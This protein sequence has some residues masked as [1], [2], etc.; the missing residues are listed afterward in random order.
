MMLHNYRN[1]YN[2]WK[3]TD[4]LEK[5][6]YLRAGGT[7][8]CHSARHLCKKQILK[9]SKIQWKRQTLT[10]DKASFNY[11]QKKANSLLKQ[12][13]KM[14]PSAIPKT[15]LGFQMNVAVDGL[16]INTPGSGDESSISNI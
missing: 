12:S 8:V 7:F 9:I 4:S 1:N 10:N 14:G 2:L 15:G 6:T 16:Y 3:S 5:V 11:K 13:P